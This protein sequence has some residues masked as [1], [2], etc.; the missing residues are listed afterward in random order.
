MLSSTKRGAGNL[1]TCSELAPW[2]L[3]YIQGLRID[4][5]VP[6][7]DCKDPRAKFLD[8]GKINKMDLNGLWGYLAT[9]KVSGNNASTGLQR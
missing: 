5:I 2:L 6:R 8:F 7:T 3:G 4:A 1:S 9:G